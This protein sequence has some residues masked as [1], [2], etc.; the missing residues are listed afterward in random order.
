MEQSLIDMI[1]SKL[2]GINHNGVHPPVLYDLFGL[3]HSNFHIYLGDHASYIAY[4][5]A[6]ILAHDI[7]PAHLSTQLGLSKLTIINQLN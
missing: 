6:G 4:N 3:S 5:E 1:H 2:N 7:L